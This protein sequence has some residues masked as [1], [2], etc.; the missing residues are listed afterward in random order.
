MKKDNNSISEK[1]KIVEGLKIAYQ[2]LIKSKHE[3]SGELIIL[4]DN[5]IVKIKP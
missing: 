1:E 5:K 3:S 2:K 4:K